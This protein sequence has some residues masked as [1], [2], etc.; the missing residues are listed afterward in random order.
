MGREAIA[1]GQGAGGEEKVWRQEEG[2]EG[3]RGAEMERVKEGQDGVVPDTREGESFLGEGSFAQPQ[4]LE[5]HRDE[6]SGGGCA[7]QIRL[8]ALSAHVLWRREETK[9]HK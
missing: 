1:K 8:L 3:V 2:E 5:S 9:E 7:I 4:V 6:R